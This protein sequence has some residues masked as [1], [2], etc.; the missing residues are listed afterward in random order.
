M[1]L[2]FALQFEL[3]DATQILAQDF[4][5]D[6]EL[7]FVAGVLVVASAAAAEVFALWLD[8]MRRSFDDRFRA[9]ASEAGLFFGERR[10]NCFSGENQRD[11]DGLAASAVVTA[12][13][14]MRSGWKAGEA[15]A[16]VDEFF[17]C[18]EQEMILR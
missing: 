1:H 11:E 18:E 10:F 5:L 8:A 17:D 4:F 9:C 2:D 12:L 6:F 7:M 15:V 3:G 13:V 16:A 14:S